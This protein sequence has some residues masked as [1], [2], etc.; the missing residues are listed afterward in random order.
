MHFSRKRLLILFSAAVFSGLSAAAQ[1]AAATV[2]GEGGGAGTQVASESTRQPARKEN[3]YW[4]EEKGQ[5]TWRSTFDTK[6]DTP[7][8]QWALAVQTRKKGLLK[9]AERRMIYLYRRW[10]NSIQAPLAARGRA[11]MLF[12]RGQWKEAFTA[13][14]YLIDNYSG[15]MKDYDSAL[16]AQYEIA[17]KIMNRRRLRWVFGGYRT[18][19]YAVEYFESVV[20]NGPQW[21][22]APEAQYMV[23]K[24]NQDAGEFELAISAYK[25]LGYRYPDSALAEEAAWGQIEC[26]KELRREY[27][28]APEILDRMLTS[29]TVFLSTFPQS[30]YRTEIIQLR[31][32]LYEVKAKQVFDTAVFYAEV[33]K[34]PEAAILSY[35]KMI[36]EFPKSRLVPQ[37][38]EAIAEL[39]KILAMPVKA[40]TPDAPRSRPI[41]FTKG[42]GYVES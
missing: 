33:P 25:V 42:S 30:H 13:Y 27:P 31:N 36:E 4:V 24:C 38:Y 35:R 23:G 2:D 17:V 37:A 29:T 8:E 1:P 39:E 15:Q 7:E 19:E 11:D 9:K 10:P 20:R 40:R 16:Q 41:P 21:S 6:K 5:H 22:R 12:E 18:P 34:E 3:V 14:Q 32:G 28:A 26:Y